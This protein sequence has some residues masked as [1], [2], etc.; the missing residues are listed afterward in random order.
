MSSNKSLDQS[1]SPFVPLFSLE[2]F[3]LSGILFL[4]YYPLILTKRHSVLSDLRFTFLFLS[5][6]I[7][8][9]SHSSDDDNEIESKTTTSPPPPPTIEQPSLMQPPAVNETSTESPETSANAALSRTTHSLFAKLTDAKKSL[10]GRTN[11]PDT[12]FSSATQNKA[13][14][15]YILSEPH[16]K[17]DIVQE[18][19]NQGAQLNATTDEGNTALHLL[20]RTEIRSAESIQIVEFLSKKGGCDPNKQNDY[21][22][23][24]GTTRI[25]EFSVLCFVFLAHYA[26][27]TR[28]TDLAFSLFKAM[29]DVNIATF[30]PHFGETFLSLFLQT[31]RCL[32]FRL[33]KSNP[34]FA[35]RC[36]KKR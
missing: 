15:T 1:S 3:F 26:L 29:S 16:P 7:R 32:E 10:F 13:L 17:L 20:A 4:E 12:M 34:S 2:G 11:A 22:W 31:L 9:P 6:L 14:L 5:S 35:Y 30:E 36:T 25:F 28:N 33:S 23:T 27:A 24:A 19:E 21:G 18:F 8:N